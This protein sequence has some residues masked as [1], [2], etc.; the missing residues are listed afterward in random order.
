M[1]GAQ[2]IVNHITRVREDKDKS[3]AAIWKVKKNTHHSH[4]AL[5]S[6]CARE[7]QVLSRINERSGAQPKVAAGCAGRAPL[8]Y[9]Q[10][11]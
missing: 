10:V 9:S 3:G 6:W 8:D 1:G 2:R 5:D 7:R 4:G 11:R